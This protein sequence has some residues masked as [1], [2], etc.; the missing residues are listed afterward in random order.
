MGKLVRSL[1][2][3]QLIYQNIPCDTQIAMTVT[4][5]NREYNVEAS[6]LVQQKG[7]TPSLCW[8]SIVAWQNGSL[9]DTNGEIRLGTPFLSGVYA[10]VI[11]KW[12]ELTIG[13]S[14]IRTKSNL[15]DLLGNLIRSMTSTRWLRSG[16]GL[17]G[18]LPVS[19]STPADI[20]HDE[21][22][23]DDQ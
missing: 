7:P 2:G 5:A 11:P 14:I 10:Y 21:V 8:S 13:H 3:I 23:A 1:P 6:Q 22:Q 9:P 17:M 19:V 16:V 20:L 18:N 12:T 4:I 15:W